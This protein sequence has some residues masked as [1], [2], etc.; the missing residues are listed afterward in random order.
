MARAGGGTGNRVPLGQ[1]AHDHTGVRRGEGS[2]FLDY[3]AEDFGVNGLG[4]DGAER[5]AH[6]HQDQDA[7]WRP[8]AVVR[9]VN[10]DPRIKEQAE[11]LSRLVGHDAAL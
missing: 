4:D 7:F 11:G 1:A 6:G 2:C 5:G 8:P 3:V 10:H 9:T